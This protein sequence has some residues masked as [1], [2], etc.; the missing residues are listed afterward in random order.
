MSWGFIQI[1][2]ISE[3]ASVL[4]EKENIVTAD[5][6]KHHLELDSLALIIQFEK[7][8]LKSVLR[9]VLTALAAV[10]DFQSAENFSLS[11]SVYCSSIVSPRLGASLEWADCLLFRC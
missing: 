6:D 8:T 4:S 3:S 1:F 2:D 10:Y 5:S 7:G 9:L 11:N